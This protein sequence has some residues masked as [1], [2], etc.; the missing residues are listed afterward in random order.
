MLSTTS[1]PV[2]TGALK[3]APLLCTRVKVFN[4]WVLPIAPVTNTVPPVPAFNTTD[5]VLWA[6]P[7]RVLAKVMLA[8]VGSAPLL[9]VSN[10]VMAAVTTAWSA[11]RME[12]GLLVRTMPPLKVL[13]PEASVSKC[14]GALMLPIAPA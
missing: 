2:V 5:W 1:V 9:V 6:T 13:L 7:L 10:V 11:M 14:A 12:L 8:P 4:A 3:T